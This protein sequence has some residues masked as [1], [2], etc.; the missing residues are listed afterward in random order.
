MM[1][2]SA[3]Y[4]G[5]PF[6]EKGR[7][8]AGLDCWGLVHLVYRQELGIELPSYVEGYASLAERA[9][10]SALFE[11]GRSEPDWS[12][13]DK[14]QEFDVVMLRMGRLGAHVGIVAGKKRMLH[15][16][17]GA[18]SC[19]EDFTGHRF[20]SRVVGIYRHALALSIAA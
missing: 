18:A 3:G 11:A 4:I 1:H 13:V 5:L 16:S 19:I 20:E 7:S 15:I 17:E 9:E 12:L 6:A 10:I 8:R 2:W 14:P